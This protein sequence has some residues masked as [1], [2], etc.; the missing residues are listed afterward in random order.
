MKNETETEA[1][2]VSTPSFMQEL[3]RE[4][5]E[6]WQ[7]IREGWSALWVGIGNSLRSMRGEPIDYV[8]MSLSGS[9]PQRDEP[10]RRFIER[11]L[12]LPPPPLSLETLDRRLRLIA[13]AE[14]VHG[15]IFVLRG[16]SAGLAT[17]QSLRRAIARLREAGKEVIVYTPYL[18]LPHYF[19]AAAADRII[20]PPPAQFDVL[21]VRSE[22]TF[23]KDALARLGIQADVVQISPYKSAFNPFAQ[24]DLT[25]EHREQLTWLL[26]DV[27]DQ[28]V[29]DMANGR[30]FT[31]DDLRDLIDNAPYTAADALAH[32]LIDHLAY[33]DELAALLAPQA[34]EEAEAAEPEAPATANLQTWA[35]AKRLLLRKPR[36]TTR[37][38]IGVVSLEGTIATGESQNPPGDLPLPFI[39]GGVIGEQ[40]VLRLLRRAEQESRMAALILHV[41][42]G[43]GSALASDLIAREVQRI[44]Q[45]MPVLVYMGDTAASGGYLISAPAQHIMCQPMTMTGSIGVITMRLATQGLFEKLSLNQAG[46]QRGRRADLYSQSAPMSVEERELFWQMVVHTYQQF[47]QVV[48]DGRSLPLEELDPICEGRVWT[49][50]QAQQHKLVDSFGDFQDA[51][52]QTAALAELDLADGREPW[53]LNLHS[54]RD[55]D[56]LPQPFAAAQ[57]LALLLTG[58]R[59]KQ[60]VN[61]PLLL[62]P[63][64]FRWQ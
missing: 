54:Q 9:L 47:K 49:G 59:L 21:G 64:T 45:K 61:Q 53:V 46:V 26:D 32:G 18:D 3:G 62:L 24:D 58:Q 6:L 42:S 40:T 25:A 14:N 35:D 13:A 22:I 57:E 48:A 63:F 50:R 36:R 27:Y 28:L 51:I 52:Q 56:E 37:Q 17:L 60:W 44:G 39:G 43:G 31:P 15:V 8:T 10:P 29:T 11:Q 16:L 2:A 12:P 1:T 19:V 41:D 33:E 55:G 5:G 38:F 7:S 34:E 23:F 4:L 30:F 20:A